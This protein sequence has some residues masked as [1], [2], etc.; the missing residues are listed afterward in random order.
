MAAIRLSLKK[1]VDES[2]DIHIGSGLLQEMAK[3]AKAMGLRSCVIT[4]SNTEGL[5]SRKVLD[6]L[7][8]AHVAAELVSI[9]PGEAGKSRDTKALI[10]DELIMNGFGRDTLIIALGGGV[11]GDLAGFVAATYCRG[12]P[13]IHVPTTLLSMVDSSIGGKTGV[14][15]RHGKNLIGAFWQP[16]AVFSDLDFLETLPAREM[17]SGLAECIKHAMIADKK[18]FEYLERDIEKV[19]AKDKN[20][21]MEAISRCAAVKS[22]IVMKDERESMLR[23]ALN[24]GHTIGHAVE[25]LSSYT[26]SHGEAISIGMAVEACLAEKAMK[27]QDIERQ[28]SLLERAGLPVKVPGDIKTADIIAKTMLDKKAKNRQAEYA[29]LGG[30]GKVDRLRNVDEELVRKSIDGS[31]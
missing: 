16:K 6:A 13:Y 17:G 12:V 19:L 24:Y 18:L 22:A 5:F 28:N 26:L 29:L 1:A 10:E 3:F 8:K 9:K 31:R 15:T 2:Y 14:D 4:D 11:V 23:K 25:Q 30:I 21:L 27:K 20:A 7:E